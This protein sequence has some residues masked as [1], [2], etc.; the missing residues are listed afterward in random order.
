MEDQLHLAA[1]NVPAQQRP[2]RVQAP[3]APARKVHRAPRLCKRH[4]L[5]RH[6]PGVPV[7]AFWQALPAL[8]GRPLEA[9]QIEHGVPR[10]RGRGH[11]G[12]GEEQ[13]GQQGQRQRAQGPDAHEPI[14]P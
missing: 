10:R 13:R 3:P 5:A 14:G 12:P 6:R 9:E 8:D 2:V 11:H 1:W 7:K 4:T